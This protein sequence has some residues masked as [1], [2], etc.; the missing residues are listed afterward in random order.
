MPSGSR[1]YEF[2]VS[3]AVLVEATASKAYEICHLVGFKKP[4]LKMLKSFI[5]YPVKMGQWEKERR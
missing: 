5:E 2:S 4:S 3:V 1:S